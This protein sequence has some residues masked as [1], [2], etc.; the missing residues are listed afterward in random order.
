MKPI[1]SYHVSNGTVKIKREE[2]SRPVLIT[3]VTDFDKHFS[4]IDLNPG[5]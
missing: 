1:Y 3:H 4:G 2:N 5:S